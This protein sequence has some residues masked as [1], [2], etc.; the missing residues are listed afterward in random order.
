MKRLAL[1]ATILVAAAGCDKAK[2]LVGLGRPQEP[3]GPPPSPFIDSADFD[4]VA[5]SQDGISWYEVQG[6]RDLAA[7]NAQRSVD[8]DAAIAAHGLAYNSTFRLRFNQYDNFSIPTD[9]IAID[10]ISITGLPTRRLI[11]TVPDFTVEEVS[12]GM[13]ALNVVELAARLTVFRSV[14]PR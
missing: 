11:V 13:T 7:T 3:D 5:V 8:L 6:L 12:I 2:S 4:G 10:D 14:D 1:I 9:G